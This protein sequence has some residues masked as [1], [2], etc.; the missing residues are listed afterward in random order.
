MSQQTSRWN[1][2]HHHHPSIKLRQYFCAVS[3]DIG[4]LRFSMQEDKC[5]H[6]NDNVTNITSMATWKSNKIVMLQIIYERDSSPYTRSLDLNT[7]QS[8]SW[9]NFFCRNILFTEMLLWVIIHLIR[10]ANELPDFIFYKLL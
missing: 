3:Q 4:P 9:W 5:D 7:S 10:F 2:H 6:M 1:H 8:P